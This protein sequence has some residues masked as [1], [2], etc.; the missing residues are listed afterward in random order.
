MGGEDSGLCE[1][2]RIVR[3]DREGGGFGEGL[4]C[5]FSVMIFSSSLL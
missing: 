1:R 3:D 4:R 5:D 2:W